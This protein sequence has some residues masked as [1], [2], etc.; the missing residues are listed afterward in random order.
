MPVKVQVPKKKSGLVHILMHPFGKAIL[1]AIVFTVSI[2]LIVFTYYYSKYSRLIETKLASPFGNTST[3][4][5]A[6]R[7]SWWA[8]TPPRS[9]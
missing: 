4:Y 1:A 7:S 5:A 6:P 9:N 2:G 8:M 3:L